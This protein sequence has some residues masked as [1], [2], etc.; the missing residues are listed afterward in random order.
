MKLIFRILLVVAALATTYQL[1]AQQNVVYSHYY[2]N[3]FLY[4]PS[5]AASNG[6]SEL[7]LNYR[8]QWSGL[9]GAPTTGTIS[10]QLPLNPK[11]GLGF[12][13]LVDKAGVLSTSTG[14]ASFTYQVYLGSRVNDEHKI[15]FGLSAG[16]SSV[17]IEPGDSY[18]NDP[19]V[20]TSTSFEGQFGINYRL[21]NLRLATALPHFQAGV[22]QLRTTISSASYAIQLSE[23]I[24]LE[25]MVMYRTYEH[26]SAQVEG[27]GLLRI[28]NKVWVGA[29]YR[30]RYG[31]TALGGFNY[32]D[33]LKLAYAYEFASTP[34]NVL[35]GATHEIQLV[36]R[37]G[38]KKEVGKTKEHQPIQREVETPDPEV[39]E[40][41]KSEVEG[42]E[43]ESPGHTKQ[44][45]EATKNVSETSPAREQK[46]EVE[47]EEQDTEIDAEEEE[48]E[49]EKNMALEEEAELP[50]DTEQ[51]VEQTEKVYDI[52]PDV[53]AS[54]VYGYENVNPDRYYVVVGA[55][56]YEENAK[57]F[58]HELRGS[59]YP[60]SIVFQPEK[61]FY[62]VY[63]ED[64]PTLDEAREVCN[65]YRQ[66]S[67]YSFPDTW[68]L[69]VSE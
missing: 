3:P 15:A 12:T 49:E 9:E 40:E 56:R 38:K 43:V 35:G 21:R 22:D 58:H 5:F 2:L 14:M 53:S 44:A 32:K 19:V 62:I 57:A 6:Y 52:S 23:R 61:K 39:D 10:L 60:A 25:P 55:F 1:H 13:G 30:Q 8:N 24:E 11:V 50:D 18:A 48:E 17:S 68:I 28:D 66:L 69:K 59:G 65:Q 63:V 67:E 7:Y 54:D 27:L 26:T 34:L 29:S 47:N 41:E 4:N 42:N 37:L 64:A 46:S 33:K 31:A 20:G 45:V 16:A 51:F 36:L